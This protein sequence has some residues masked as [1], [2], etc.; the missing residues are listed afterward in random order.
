MNLPNVNAIGFLRRNAK[1]AWLF[2][3]S[4]KSTFLTG[5]AMGGVFGISASSAKAGIKSHEILQN[6]EDADTIEKVKAVA[7]CWVEPGIWIM[8]VETMILG[9]HQDAMSKIATYAT[10]WSASEKN[11][12]DLQ[13]QVEEVVGKKKAADIQQAVDQK[14]ELE[15]Y[16]GRTIINTGRGKTIFKDAASGQL[17]L[18]DRAYVDKVFN[19]QNHFLNQHGAGGDNPTLVYVT[20]NDI[21]REWGINETEKG[22]L[23]GWNSYGNLIDM[24]IDPIFARNGV[25]VINV[26][27]LKNATPTFNDDYYER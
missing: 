16:D 10:M 18:S 2:Y 26:I 13:E 12:K 3:Q 23:E 7:P 27:H 4:N 9:A 6:M 25:D 11:L 20:Y 8:L 5:F 21:Y 19:E 24:H 22:E 15:S 14:Q 17:F 1:I